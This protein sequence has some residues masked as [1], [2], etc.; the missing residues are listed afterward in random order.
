MHGVV[1]KATIHD[2]EQARN[3]LRQEGIPR[4]S[5]APGFVTAH[6]VRLSES[7]GTSMLIFESE[8]AAQA[9]AEQLKSNPP[10]GNA[11]T[12]NSVEIGEVVEQA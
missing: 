1:V 8:E 2:F 11:V 12:I 6:W 9:G 7:S 10:P 4:L 3:F 5:Q